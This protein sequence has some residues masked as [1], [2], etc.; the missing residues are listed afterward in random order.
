MTNKYRIG[1]IVYVDD[2]Y[3][4]PYIGVV[5]MLY[6]DG[7]GSYLYNI[8]KLKNK[9]SYTEQIQEEVSEMYIRLATDKDYDMFKYIH[10]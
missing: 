5:D 1:D 7:Y 6:P 8:K 3:T 2:I 10:L 9:A 4:L